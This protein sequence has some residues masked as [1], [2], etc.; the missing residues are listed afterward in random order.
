MT[1]ITSH[2]VSPR[3]STPGPQP[4][5]DVPTDNDTIVNASQ[6]AL[7]SLGIFSFIVSTVALVLSAYTIIKCHKSRFNLVHNIFE[8]LVAL[9]ERATVKQRNAVDMEENTAYGVTVSG[10]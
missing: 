10:G 9:S 5:S 8:L 7:I 1:N 3:V 6:V 4:T 2:P